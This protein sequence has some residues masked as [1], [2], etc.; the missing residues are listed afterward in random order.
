MWDLHQ[1]SCYHVVKSC[2]E[3]DEALDVAH[4]DDVQGCFVEDESMAYD[5]GSKALGGNRLSLRDSTLV[6]YHP[7]HI[8]S[9]TWLEIHEERVMEMTWERFGQLPWSLLRG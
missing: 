2:K 1:T 4:D 9:M 3:K 6:D 7:R 8:S 5:V